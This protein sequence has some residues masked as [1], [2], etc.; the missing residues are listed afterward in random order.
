MNLNEPKRTSFVAATVVDIV[1]STYPFGFVFICFGK[2]YCVP[3]LLVFFF[4]QGEVAG[5]LRERQRLRLGRSSSLESP[6]RS[7]RRPQGG[8]VEGPDAG[9][10]SHFSLHPDNGNVS[11]AAAEAEG[12]TERDRWRAATGDDPPAN[13]GNSGVGRGV[14][15]PW[16]SSRVA[17]GLA[18]GGGD[19]DWG[20]SV[21]K[22]RPAG[23]SGGSGGPGGPGGGMHDNRVRPLPARSRESVEP[24]R[25]TTIQTC[26][27]DER[28]AFIRDLQVLHRQLEA[29]DRDRARREREHQAA[30]SRAKAEAKAAQERS[31]A[32]RREVEEASVARSAAEA[33]AEAAAESLDKQVAAAEVR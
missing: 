13:G 19:R 4:L 7:G 12:A 11:E 20:G 10:E 15:S 17:G 18:A 28:E 25:V 30:G 8:F 3:R 27:K 16:L 33:R 26:F 21:V 6:D 32:F 29:K 24:Q 9:E 14:F 1:I 5:R 31:D 23:G 22:S 2:H